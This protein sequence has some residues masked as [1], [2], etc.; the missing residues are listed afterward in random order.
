MVGPQRQLTLSEI[1]RLRVYEAGADLELGGAYG[2]AT[3]LWYIVRAGGDKSG[4]TGPIDIVTSLESITVYIV[5][6]EVVQERI[7]VV[8][9]PTQLG[10]WTFVC[11]DNQLMAPIV[12]DTLVDDPY[13]PQYSYLIETIAHVPGVFI[14]SVR[15]T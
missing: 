7:S 14:G 2:L 9:Q 11:P 15:H 12:G 6:S 5:P 8:G 1:D 3:R 4:A 13:Q 10:T